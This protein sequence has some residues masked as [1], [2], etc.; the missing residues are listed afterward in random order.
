MD[1]SVIIVN[2]NTKE[3]LK[4]CLLS[5]FA[6]KTSF[7]FEVWVSDNGSTDGS[8]EMVKKEFPQV[9][10]SENGANLGFSKANNIALKQAQGE[11]LLLLNSDTEVRPETLT[12]SMEYIKEHSEV[13][14]LGCKVLLP[15]GQLDPACRRR[16]PN[17]TNAFLRLFGLKKFSD[18]N[19]S[20]DINTPQEVDAVMGAYLLIRKKV[21]EKIGF[22]DEDYFMYG[23]DLD[24]CW[25]AKQAG[26]QV[27]YYPG[28]EITHYKYGSS[29]KVSVPTIR[30]AH[31]AMK[32]FYRKHYAASRPQLFN[33]LVYFGIYI[34]Q[35]LVMGKNLL[36][37]KKFVH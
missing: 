29:Q 8:I 23:E 20:G 33:Q 19:V 4:R 3:L 35:A 22:L 24:W 5:V 1:L 15:N 27:Y 2:Y 26:Y 6:S 34:H 14:V 30:F 13:G 16:F 36:E 9:R 25:R 18:Y 28:A 7:S 11:N 12:R 17:P 21:I 10:L 31:Q 32:I 37:S